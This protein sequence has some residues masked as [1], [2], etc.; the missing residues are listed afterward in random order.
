MD[1][2]FK[3]NFFYNKFEEK[4]KKNLQKEME[5]LWQLKNVNTQNTL[6]D[7]NFTYFA[8]PSLFSNGE[9][10]ELSNTK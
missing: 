8:I 5:L 10:E 6:L 4:K 1:K 9:C 7:S 3:T 2:I